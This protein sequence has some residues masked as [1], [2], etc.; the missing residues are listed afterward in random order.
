MLQKESQ[1]RGLSLLGFWIKGCG[2][3]I[4]G[5]GSSSLSFLFFLVDKAHRLFVEKYLV[6]KA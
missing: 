5:V 6:E 3:F 4:K 1:A 2:T